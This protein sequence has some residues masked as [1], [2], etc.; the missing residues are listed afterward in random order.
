M[1]NPERPIG[2]NR[3]AQM[4][5]E[6]AFPCGFENTKQ[7]KAHGKCALG[8]T[9]LSNS[10][11]SETMKLKASRHSNLK[12]HARYQRINDENIEK[13]HE[14]MDPLLLDNTSK[15]AIDTNQMQPS[16]PAPQAKK[17]TLSLLPLILQ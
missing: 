2:H 7:H 4:A 6:F 13:K 12:S 14:A 5:P 8:I 15:Y 10:F 11:V 1:S 16:T 3:L 17:T 9:M